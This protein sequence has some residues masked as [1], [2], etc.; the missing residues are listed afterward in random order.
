MDY[1]YEDMAE[2]MLT[3]IRVAKPLGLE[4]DFVASVL[5]KVVKRMID[6]EEFQNI[7]REVA[8]NLEMIEDEHI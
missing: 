6:E 4:T 3:G 1:K 5:E 2:M 8:L 7:L